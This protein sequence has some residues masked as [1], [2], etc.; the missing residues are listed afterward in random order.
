MNLL[1]YLIHLK[2][3]NFRHAKAAD[4]QKSI[5]M[6]QNLETLDVRKTNV[7]ELP[8]EIRTLR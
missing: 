2:Y 5:G 7:I 6:L 8:K 3:L 4:V 1:N